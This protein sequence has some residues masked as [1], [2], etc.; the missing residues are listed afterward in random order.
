MEN[1]EDAQV[2]NFHLSPSFLS[3]FSIEIEVR[4]I[5]K[6]YYVFPLKLHMN[7]KLA[8]G[9]QQSKEIAFNLVNSISRSNLSEKSSEISKERRNETR[10]K[11][12]KKTLIRLSYSLHPNYHICNFQLFKRE[13]YTWRSCSYDAFKFY[14]F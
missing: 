12:N 10:Q 3:I 7:T 14:N 8:L 4:V 1:W 6:A 9:I 2:H 13:R 11:I 5:E